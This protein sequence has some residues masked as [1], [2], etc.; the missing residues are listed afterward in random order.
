[1]KKNIQLFC[2]TLLAFSFVGN[3]LNAQNSKEAKTPHPDAVNI[4]LRYLEKQQNAWH[5]TPEDVRN[6]RVQDFYSTEAN[7]LTHV[8]ILQENAN[9]EL[10]N[11][12]VNVNVMPSGEVLYAGN[13]FM[14]NF[15]AAVNA[16][17][18]QL[19]PQAAIKA[20][21][22][23]LKVPLTEGL[24]LK[25]QPSKNE[26]IFDKGTFV[27]SDVNVK[28]KYQR[29]TE[30]TARLAWDINIDQ[31]DGQ[32][33]WSVR[34]DALTG[35]LLNKVSYTVHC[36]IDHN[37]YSRSEGTCNGLHD[38]NTEGGSRELKIK[39]LELLAQNTASKEATLTPNSSNS[40]EKFKQLAVK[41]AENKAK[42]VK[43]L[44]TLI[45]G[46][47]YN[48]FA[49]PTESPNHGNRSIVLDP[50][51]SLAS[52]FG[53]H[54]TN[55]AAG[56]EYTITRGNNAWAFLDLTNTNAS[57]GDEPNGGP[58]LTFNDYFSLTAEPDSVKQAATTNLFYMNNMIHDITYRYGFDE[59]AGNFQFKNYS[60]QAAGGDHVLAQAQDSRNAT[61]P[62]RNNANFA[63]PP[64]GGSGRMQMYV[65]NDAGIQKLLHVT[66]PSALI[67]DIG[68]TVAAFGGGVST[69]PVTGNAVFV[70]DGTGS[71]TL[72]CGTAI[73]TNLTG[74][75]ALIDRG[76]CEFGYKALKAQQRGAIA[77]VIC[78]FDENV[79]GMA[80]GAVGGQVTIP[81]IGIAKSDA[82][83]MRAAASAGTLQLSIYTTSAVKPAEVDGDFD[84][85]IIIHEYMHGISN[86]LTGG[87]LNTSCLT[88][89]EQGGEGWS[90]FLALALTARPSDRG[91]TIRGVGT[92]AA[93]QPIA[94]TGIRSTPY[95]TNQ[96]ISTQTYDDLILNPEVHGLGEIWCAALWDVYW[97]M[98]DQ[99][100]WDANWKNLTSG[101]GRT[102]RLV[103]DAMK[104][105]PCN[106]GLLDARD[107][108]LAADR[109][110]GG[111]NQCL[112]WDAFARRGMG[113]NA[114][115]GSANL[116]D[117][118]TEGTER[119]PYCIK[120]LKITKSAAD[121]IK[122]GDQITYTVQV[123]N[124]K[125]VVAS[126]VV[127]T[128]EVPQ[129]ATYA[130]G[131]ASRA[132]TQT[133]TSLSFA[134]GTMNHNDTVTFT[135]KVN[136]DVNKKSLAQ[137]LD[138]LEAGDGKWDYEST[139]NTNIWELQTLYARSGTKAL[140]VG[141]AT[142]PGVSDQATKFLQPLTV[143]GAKPILNFY[144][145]YDTEPGFDGGILQV[146]TDNGVTWRDM[147]D[148][149][150]KGP[151]RGKFQYSIFA[152]PNQKAWWGAVNQFTPVA[153]DL[154]SY[155]GQ[156][157][158]FRW[159]FGTD[160]AD[161]RIGWFVDDVAV[162]DMINYDTRVRLSSAQG[163]TASAGV[164]GRG[165]IVEPTL[166]TPT[167]EI[168]E[169][170]KLRVFPNPAHDFLNINLLVQQS[171][172]EADISIVS[173][174]GRVMWQ[175]KAALNGAKELLLPVNMATFASGVYFVKVRT[176][177]KTLVEK[178]IRQ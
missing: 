150:F 49:L 162:M 67:S 79:A 22:E 145:R 40:V 1:M 84:N 14:S 167:A 15:A 118:N 42:T 74:K 66:A 44:E 85:G 8:Y 54:D 154:S 7:G 2:L 83:R 155:T 45:G 70:N 101:N 149:I 73:Q 123:I 132:V 140:G 72:A 92:Y 146:T 100:G 175:Q 134:I 23:A 135:Y 38:Q 112:I 144:H 64:D 47:S 93:R 116:A 25:G 56:P 69:T 33:H 34:I 120:T 164:L 19:T 168:T 52:P 13:R 117:D 29:M 41:T 172:T 17:Q 126:N 10:F 152:I 104:I 98:C 105:Q 61:T 71:P 142:T 129:F 46:G 31:P 36:T 51:D 147:G 62:A 81:V 65:W 136:T 48:V 157:V 24:T 76:G 119:Y 78:F 170:A 139:R 99:Y 63:T 127:V 59:P 18:P 50:A 151:Y 26:F 108:I 35:K 124:H 86:R 89:A 77:V 158:N 55:G 12:L 27:L 110:N 133:G 121:F 171:I 53:W 60:G 176:N 153:V 174:D 103:M 128:D 138:N 6:V 3:I 178:V 137:F 9:I 32:D 28:L 43:A 102:I 20:A 115:Q 21:C 125:G 5:L 173:V 106:P 111:A 80:A 94:G 4:A 30:T 95:T 39:N 148:K 165:T 122:A 160:S 131:S 57:S 161:A 96:A 107:A 97:A 141:Y 82:D 91:T 113:Y 11:G 163:D 130:A 58:T 68:A 37:R 88:N 143:R 16:T 90:D 177:E 87:R 75:I 166:S 109:A 169:G 156:S 114:K 159:R